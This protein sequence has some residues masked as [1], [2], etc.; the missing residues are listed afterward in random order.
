MIL[1]AHDAVG[2]A[3]TKKP[4][5]DGQQLRAAVTLTARTASVM[6]AMIY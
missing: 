4:K 1:T 3:S 2:A 6:G 5:K